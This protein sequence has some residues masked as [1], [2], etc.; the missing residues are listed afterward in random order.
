MK[1]LLADQRAQD[2]DILLIQEP[3]KNPHIHTTHNPD[4]TTWDLIYAAKPN[5]RS[6]IFINK[7]RIAESS[8]TVTWLEEDIC[9]IELTV[10]RRQGRG[11][12][13]GEDETQ[14][15]TTITVIS[16]YNPS[17][18]G[19][20]E[21][22][23]LATLRNIL[24]VSRELTIV[25]GDFNLHHPIWT[26][27]EYHH[28]HRAA[29][30]L[31][32]IMHSSGLNLATPVGTITFDNGYQTTI[33]LAMCSTDL[34]ECLSTCITSD[35]LAHDSD[36]N[37]TALCLNIAR[38]EVPSNATRRRWAS[39]DTAALLD[40]FRTEIQGFELREFNTV[41]DIDNA[42]TD[43]SAAINL[44]VEKATPTSRVCSRSKPGFN[45]HCKM[46]C[47]E[48]QRLRRQWQDTRLAEDREAYQ[49]SLKQ[50]RTILRQAGSA[51]F[52]RM[53]EETAAT[54]AGLWKLAKWS[55]NRATIPGRIPPLKTAEGTTV[56]TTDDKARAFKEIFY[57]PVRQADLS[58]IGLT[59]SPPPICEDT[60]ITTEEIQ[61]AIA[62][63]PPLK[64]PGPDGIPN[65]ILQRIGRPL[66]IILVRVFNACL[67]LGY[68][69][70]HF[71]MQETS[72]IRKPQKPDY[73][74]AK[75]YRP[76]ALLNTM[77]KILETVMASRL[78]CLAT[79]KHLLPSRHLGGLA[80]TGTEQALHIIVEDI[81]N[82]W[83]K[84][85][86]VS[87]L[88][89][90][91]E[92]AFPN[93]NGE[94]L[95]E[96]LRRK[97]IPAQ[98]LSWI[99]SFLLDERQTTMKFDNQTTQPMVIQTGIPQGSPIS[100]I[101]FLFY[102]A[103]ILE[104]TQ[105]LA[106][107]ATVAN[108][109]PR[110]TG[111]ID[112]VGLT[113]SGD[114]PESNCRA[115]EQLHTLAAESWAATHGAKF[116]TTKYELIHFTRNSEYV[117]SGASVTLGQ[118]Q[119]NPSNAVRY[120]G[121]YLDRQLRWRQQMEAVVTRGKKSIGALRQLSRSTWGVSLGNMRKAYQAIVIPQLLYASS[122]WYGSGKRKKWMVDKLSSLQHEAGVVISGAFRATSR[123]ALNVE[124]YLPPIDIVLEQRNAKTISRL[125]TVPSGHA[126]SQHIDT[127]FRKGVR[128]APYKR[129]ASPLQELGEANRHLF[130]EG[131]RPETITPYAV[132]P[133]VPTP[134]I[135]I[136]NS[137]EEAIA[138]HDSLRESCLD[139]LAIYTDGSGINGKVGSAAVIPSQPNLTA[140]AG[141]AE[142]AYI[143]SD[144]E[145]NVY[146]AELQGIFMALR[147]FD[148]DDQ[149]YQKA[150]IY[151][152]NQAAIISSHKPRQQS[153]QH[154]IK[155]ILQL[156]NCLRQR[157]KTVV[158][159]WIPA[160]E[161]V[162][163]NERADIAAKLATGWRPR[164]R[165]TSPCSAALVWDITAWEI[166][167]LNPQDTELTGPRIRY[168]KLRS[169]LYRQ[170]NA[171]L[172]P[173]WRAQWNASIT[174]KDL[175]HLD[176]TLPSKKVLGLH[177]NHK[178]SN[179]LL[180]QL[181]TEKVGLRAFLHLRKVPGYEHEG[182]NVCECEEA[183]QTAKHVL[184]QCPI[185]R[186]QRR[187]MQL[188]GGEAK[189]RDIKTLLT[190]KT[191]VGLAV[192][193]MA[194]TGVLKQYHTVDWSSAELP[195]DS[196]GNQ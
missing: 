13:D 30:H 47:R 145:Q 44:A 179:S 49:Q 183:F 3:W 76:I 97:A 50:K 184:L 175:R 69:P 21:S 109:S 112:D 6:C 72:I 98:M 167:H 169:A 52:H 165:T 37:A 43:L 186:R 1:P 124:L 38:P 99:R 22:T 195:A 158:L 17:P 190:D 61:A 172:L 53:I 189:T 23:V 147:M 117:R 18:E 77:G 45:S 62:H 83:R 31:V 194:N 95:V 168:P 67:Q 68:H 82:A 86:I 5:T 56:T 73:G 181:R 143:G 192:R 144:N 121:V 24:L 148:E 26:G 173:E 118:T 122:V 51:E 161:G 20:E 108:G 110:A 135:V 25:M 41:T 4:K 40:T 106:D 28:R 16:V 157:G 103:G 132:A 196:S 55:R 46:A 170:I 185:W 160:H 166:E 94:R 111:Y 39:T 101:L 177:S 134:P 149:G 88:L 85:K 27:P 63:P 92:A 153:G 70:Q 159:Q 57:P 90:D 163:G 14:A 133:H 60:P 65:L 174:G 87:M 91:V 171:A 7:K 113:V 131:K 102:N 104:K 11:D 141:R 34:S 100:P 116:E 125:A 107:T 36:H 156:W 78:A 8:W 187:Q 42:I 75:A 81:H 74:V 9:A 115:I 114:S 80:G 151:T 71:R 182:G 35:E 146:L 12:A 152:D 105:E 64:S 2:F 193:F 154:L 164:S 180:V 29:D 191:V 142:L 58:D 130:L 188:E 176:P 127:A 89:L 140:Q 137:R 128:S 66:S 138:N 123:A 84:G 119:I 162:L 79:S 155:R 10:Q 59:E 33:D 48:A 96:N 178:P 19:D 139:E 32:D 15:T 54:E 129:F 126:L 150:R 136:H 120:L 93:V